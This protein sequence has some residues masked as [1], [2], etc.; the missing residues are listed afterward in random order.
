MVDEIDEH[1]SDWKRKA[2]QT[3]ERLKKE[4]VRVRKVPVD[5]S[6]FEL[7]CRAAKK[8]FDSASR[9]SYVQHLLQ[10]KKA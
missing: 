5:L 8:P 7:W 10:S 1:Y 6:E 4:G 9:A 3:F 2:E